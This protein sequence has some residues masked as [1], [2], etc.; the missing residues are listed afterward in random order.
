MQDEKK[1]QSQDLYRRVKGIEDQKKQPG[2]NAFNAVA[3]ADERYGLKLGNHF[4]GV[5]TEGRDINIHYWTGKEPPYNSHEVNVRISPDDVA[6]RVSRKL[7]TGKETTET[8]R[9]AK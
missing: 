5:S 3:L 4:L 1:E 2:M 7:A 9:H 8:Y 6:T